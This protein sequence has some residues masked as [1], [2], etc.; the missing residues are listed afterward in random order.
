MAI[1]AS[2]AILICICA[3]ALCE[4]W[5]L[6]NN[7]RL[8][9]LALLLPF[10][11][12]AEVINLSPADDWFAVLN[13]GGLKPG[14]EVVLAAGTYTEAKRL[15][16]KHVGTAE[17]PIIIRGAKV[18]ARP[19][20]K[21]PDAR[22]NTINMA[23]CQHVVLR[24][25]DITGGDAGIRIYKDGERQ[26]AF[27]TIE[28][29]HIH[30]IDGV[31]IT[32]NNEDCVY[33]RLIFRHNEIHH[34]GGHG[35][36]FYLGGNNDSKGKT[37]GYVFNSIVEKNYIHHLNGKN[38]SQGDGIE[39]KDGSYGNIVRGNVIHDTKY[40]GITVYGT[41]GKE[42]NLIEDNVISST[43][44]HGIQAAADAM[45]R[46]NTIFNTGGDGI[47]CRSHQSAMP[48]NLVIEKNAIIACKSGSGIR[49]NKPDKGFSGPILVKGNQLYLGAGLRIPTGDAKLKIEEN[50]K[51]SGSPK[52][53]PDGYIRNYQNEVRKF[54][55]KDLPAMD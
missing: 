40:P 27:I 47:H 55:L 7:L 4:G 32:A 3:R 43:G 35:E 42:A 8:W 1:V 38:I 13:G 48:G 28:A 5:F 51:E 6:M 22:Q 52:G 23:G 21:R 11:A 39:I 31:A 44:D 36:G 19:V 34:T 54:S 10:A 25:F 29:L 30:H 46:N 20:I 33:E 9:L 53:F 17:K 16:M 50:V 26:S 18:S 24:G 37:T 2:L 14:D 12:H 41:D 45:I 49:I 15:E